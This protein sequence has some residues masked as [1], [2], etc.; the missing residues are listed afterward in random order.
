[1]QAYEAGKIITL[2]YILQMGKLRRKE[3]VSNLP[4]VTQLESV[5]AKI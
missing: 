4:K 2:V 5:R 3:R 1:M